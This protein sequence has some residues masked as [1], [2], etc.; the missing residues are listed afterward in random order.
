MSENEIDRL[1]VKF[2]QDASGYFKSN[3]KLKNAHK[4]TLD[5]L[6]K[7]GE[8][9]AKRIESTEKKFHA[10]SL[11][12]NSSYGKK[13][14]LKEREQFDIRIDELKKFLDQRKKMI[15]KEAEQEA[16]IWKQ[17]N[18]GRSFGPG[19][20]GQ[21]V[22][23]RGGRWTVDTNRRT[24]PWSIDTNHG[25]WTMDMNHRG[26]GG[27]ASHKT[28]GLP[29]LRNMKRLEGVW[30]NLAKL[31]GRHLA[32]MTGTSQITKLMPR[33]LL[34]S[35]K[36]MRQFARFAKSGQLALAAIVGYAS[37]KLTTMLN[38]YNRDME[39]FAENSKKAAELQKQIFGQKN[40]TSSVKRELD[41]EDDYAK[42]IEMVRKAINTRTKDLVSA[43]K[44][45]K[46]YNEQQASTIHWLKRWNKQTLATHQN[47][48]QSAEQVKAAKEDIKELQELEGR[49][50]HQAKLQDQARKQ[51]IADDYKNTIEKLQDE[52]LRLM[53]QTKTVEKREMDRKGFSK[54]QQDEINRMKER[55]E[56]LAKWNELRKK[57]IKIALDFMAAAQKNKK[58]AEKELGDLRAKVALE[59]KLVNMAPEE[60]DRHRREKEVKGRVA[61]PKQQKEMLKL[62]Q[63]NE[64]IRKQQEK[65]DERRNKM[66]DGQKA[67]KDLQ[68]EINLQHKLLAAKNEEERAEVRRNHELEKKFGMF[69]NLVA[70][71][72][73]LNKEFDKN[74]KKLKEIERLE[75][76]AKDVKE[77]QKDPRLKAEEQIRDLKKLVEQGK[78]T[79]K[80]ALKEGMD[81]LDPFRA[82]AGKVIGLNAKRGPELFDKIFNRNDKSERKKEQVF[83]LKE[84]F[85]ELE[86][87]PL[88]LPAN[89]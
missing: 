69:G 9:F 38:G 66:K 60:R 4:S 12:N 22:G 57:G 40:F 29:M 37:F 21:G 82:D 54:E 72:K 79:M 42:K 39:K 61:D 70:V 41:F 26:R 50:R 86:D 18:S 14:T 1:Y 2:E 44:Q 3:E 81:I 84:I 49:F 87:R 25:D 23:R 53:G 17:T 89:L 76:L 33:S 52:N 67:R 64:D 46:K 31:S 45:Q 30:G 55:N 59:G 77:R 15:E 73:G 27:R 47:M 68:D 88:F 43:E 16:Q 32:D 65:A 63:K 35:S 13:L 56:K 75:Q 71:M 10:D 83:W 74:Q 58:D 6:E 85:D 8:D 78:L 28:M 20:S 34:K 19:N 48:A 7:M 36:A 62:M 24:N 5:K 80:E 51:R 11:E